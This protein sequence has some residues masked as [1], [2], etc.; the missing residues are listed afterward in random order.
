MQPSFIGIS[1]PS[2][3][4]NTYSTA[5][6]HTAA[7]ALKLLA[8]LRR[9]AGE[10]D[11]GAAACAIDRDLD[12]DC[13]AFVHRVDELA[14]PEIAEHAA[15]ALLGIVL[16]MLHVGEHDARAELVRDAPQLQHAL[17]VGGDLRLEVGDV[18]R[19]VA[20]RVSAAT[21]A[22]PS[23]SRSRKRPRS[24]SRKLSIS[25]PSSSTVVLFGGIEP[26]RDAAD[27]G[28]MAAR[29]RPRRSAPTAARRRTPA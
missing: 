12:V 21:A 6:R 22:A 11:D 29:R 7:G 20:R 28:V 16:H 17:G 4:R 27:I 23:S 26:G 3:V 13:A 9:R 5:A 19:H 24:T 10:I 25:T 8:L 14:A 1:S 15:H 18:L 2:N